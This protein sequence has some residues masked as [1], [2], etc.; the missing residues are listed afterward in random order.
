MLIPIEKSVALEVYYMHV[1]Q[2]TITD[3][4]K[5]ILYWNNNLVKSL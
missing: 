3:T 5:L 2:A 4:D 1:T